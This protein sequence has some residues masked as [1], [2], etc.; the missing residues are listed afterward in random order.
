MALTGPIQKLKTKRFM[1]S[2]IGF[3]FTVGYNSRSEWDGQGQTPNSEA[4]MY[5]PGISILLGSKAGTFGINIQRGYEEYLKKNASDIDET[6]KIYAI[7][8]SYR[9]VLD[10]II[11]KLYW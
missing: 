7:S 2:S 11:D 4:I 3:N 8:I 1:V 10:K 5:I 6:N 9:K